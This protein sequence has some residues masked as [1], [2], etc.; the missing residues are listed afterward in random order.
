MSGKKTA[1]LIMHGYIEDEGTG[2][3]RINGFIRYNSPCVNR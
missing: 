2:I 1:A 3:I